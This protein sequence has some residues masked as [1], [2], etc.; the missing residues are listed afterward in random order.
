MAAAAAA[1]AAA[2]ASAASQGAE[3]H[4][5]V[6]A[7]AAT[8]TREQALPIRANVAVRR[9]PP[10]VVAQEQLRDQIRYAEPARLRFWVKTL[11]EEVIR[12]AAWNRHQ[13][14]TIV[15]LRRLVDAQQRELAA[16]RVAIERLR[17]SLARCRVDCS[18]R[19]SVQKIARQ[20]LT[21]AGKASVTAE[22]DREEVEL[23]RAE[24]T[25]LKNQLATVAQ[26]SPNGNV[27][28]EDV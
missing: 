12:E 1:G 27:P 10:L 14:D 8:A 28:P 4:A 7:T 22:T 26:G 20:A 25:R 17:G 2:S 16:G 19:D 6:A 18:H 21:A 15:L 3:Q 23:L 24:N 9:P 13:G 11:R 5:G